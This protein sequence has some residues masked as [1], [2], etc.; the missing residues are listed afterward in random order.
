MS[1]PV[2]PPPALKCPSAWS[3]FTR[4]IPT[5]TGYGAGTLPDPPGRPWDLSPSP[6]PSGAPAFLSTQWRLL[7][8]RKG[9][10]PPHPR[11][12]VTQRR[13]GSPNQ[14][15][16]PAQL[17]FSETRDYFYPVPRARGTGR[18]AAQPLPGLCPPGVPL[19]TI[20]PCGCWLLVPHE[21]LSVGAGAP[22]ART[23]LTRLP[24]AGGRGGAPAGLAVPAP[25]PCPLSLPLV[26]TGQRTTPRPGTK[27]LARGHRA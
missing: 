24:R 2:L 1:Y 11:R 9:L 13:A 23:G 25:G 15:T 21:P 10:G 6:S 3:R 18:R 4:W 14:N 8:P 19:W 5:P 7:W 26:P 16:A 27:A 12:Q 22:A 20:L 17:M